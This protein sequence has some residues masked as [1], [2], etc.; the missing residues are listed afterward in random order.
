[1]LCKIGKIARYSNIAN[2]WLVKFCMFNFKIQNLAQFL[3]Y[4]NNLDLK[5]KVKICVMQNKRNS[6]NYTK[7]FVPS[8]IKR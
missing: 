7:I 1:M 2:I 3:T 6:E 4:F 8:L 5:I